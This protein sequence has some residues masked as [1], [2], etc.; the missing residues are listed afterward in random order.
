MVL[1][2]QR[3]VIVEELKK[4]KTHPTAD[5][6]YDVM[7]EKTPKISIASVYRNLEV[8][9]SMGIIAKLEFSGDKN[10][11]DADT[12]MHYHLKCSKCG[13]FLDFNPRGVKSLEKS[14]DKIKKLNDNV[15]NFNIVFNGLCSKCK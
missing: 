4:L 12:S 15:N 11:F 2:T 13:V 6:F 10:R 8:L 1:T 3:K 9:S 7:R 14:L 5:Q